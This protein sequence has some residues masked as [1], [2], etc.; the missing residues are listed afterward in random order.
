MHGDQPGQKGGGDRGGETRSE[1]VLL[2]TVEPE[3][4]G[5][6]A[7]GDKFDQITRPIKKAIDLIEVHLVHRHYAGKISRPLALGEIP[8]AACADDVDTFDIGLVHPVFE[9]HDEFFF[10]PATK[11]AIEDLVAPI[12]GFKGG[13]LDDVT[14]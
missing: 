9:F 4:I 12:N 14:L 1:T 5:I 2:L 13:S 7:F 8:V 6:L 10:A 3:Q 11:A